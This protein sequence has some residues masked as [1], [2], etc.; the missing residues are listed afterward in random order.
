[1][2]YPE[3]MQIG[4]NTIPVQVLDNP[5][6]QVSPTSYVI[7][8]YHPLTREIKIYHTDDNIRMSG[9]NFVHETIEAVNGL[10][11]LS[12]PHQ[13]ITTL[14]TAL[15][16]AYSSGNVDFSETEVGAESF[17][18]NTDWCSTHTQDLTPLQ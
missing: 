2:K 3:Q 6:R 7:G 15:Y 16:Q 13:T 10:Y 18:E 14:A 4:G 1:M 5:I 9:E 8:E 11:D 17:Q 12:L